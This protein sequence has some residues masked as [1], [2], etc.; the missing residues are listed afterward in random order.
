MN[1]IEIIPGSE[2]KNSVP[3]GKFLTIGFTSVIALLFIVGVIGW[4]ILS[5]VSRS[6]DRFSATGDLVATMDDARLFELTFTRDE[7]PTA[8]REAQES[9]QLT[10]DTAS[11]L[12]EIV[13]DPDRKERL[14]DVVLAAKVYQSEFD[15]FIDLRSKS[16]DA[17]ESMVVAAVQASQAASGLQRIQEK[18][19]RL[20]TESVRQ[21]RQQMEDI[22]ENAADSYEIVVY[23]EKSRE[24]EKN[25]LL[26]G[27]YRELELARSE[28]SNLTNT[29]NELKLR[30]RNPRSI[31]LLDDINTSKDAYLLALSALESNDFDIST[32]TL[33]SAEL[34][35]LDHAAFSMRDAAFSLRSNER[36]V[37]FEIQRIVADTQELMA[38]RLALSEEVDQIIIGVGD[39]R[40]TDRDFSLASTEAE[41]NIHAV[42]VNSLLADVISRS[43]KIQ[44]LLIE[45]DE[46]EIFENVLPS[47][48]QYREDFDSAV[49][50]SLQA[51]E[52]GRL[53]VEFALEADRLLNLAQS[54]RL[55]DISSAR[56][57]AQILAPIGIAFAA[58]LLLLVFLMRRSQQTL[59]EMANKLS[60]ANEAAEAGVKSKS[61]FLAAMSHEIRTPMNGVIGMVDLLSQTRL[62]NDQRQMLSTVQDSGHSLLTIINDIL[63][64]SKI[65]A[66]KLDIEDIDLA[67]V[68]IVEGA[69]QTIAPNAVIKGVKLLTY[70]DPEI[71]KF[72]K[73]DPTRVRQIIINMGGNAIKFSEPGK[74]VLIQAKKV[75]E[76]DEGIA[77]I[78]FSVIDQGVGISEE[79][80]KTLFTEFSQADASTTRKFGGTGL[81]LAICKRLTELMG[82][83]IGVSS[84]HGEG[85]TFW[86][87]LPFASADWTR[88][89]GKVEDLTSMRILVVSL[90]ESYRE[91]C[92]RY[93]Q[94]WNADVTVTADLN[95]CLRLSQ[96]A[97]N[98]GEPIDIIIIPDSD[99]HAKVAETYRAFLDTGMPYPR[100]VIGKDPRAE[101]NLLEGIEEVTMVDI[102]PMRRAG[103]L[104]A[105]AIAAG[106]AS[107]EVFYQKE[108]NLIQAGRTPTVEEALEQ[109]KLILFAED[110]ATNQ[111]VIR[112]QLNALG[113]QCEIA[114]DGKE[115]FE[116]WQAKPYCLLLTD[117]HMP[118]WDGFELTGAIRKSETSS[119]KRA[120]IIAITA[121]AL[122]GESERC[123]AAGM[124]DYMSKPV[125]MSALKQTL[126]KW[127]GEGSVDSDGDDG[128]SADKLTDAQSPAPNP[129]ANSCPVDDSTLKD[130]FGDDDETI[131]EILQGFLEP[132]E[133]IV[134]ELTTALKSRN[135][136]DIHNAAHKL[137]SSARSTGAN[138]LA[139]TSLA[140][141][142]AGREK[143][144]DVIEDLVPT[145]EPL[146]MAVKKYIDD[147]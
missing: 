28:V 4:G 26:S 84:V 92:R 46:K 19:T 144:W 132:T 78:R 113:Y 44:S 135:A 59:F 54:S 89:E 8:A 93:L 145:V 27:N 36:S 76:S 64:F 100:F 15:K 51:A 123:I 101:N 96:A 90:S 130:M 105:A 70:V 147:L 20:D 88:E 24:F 94:H 49:D 72:K 115:A 104:T 83:E 126:V 65:E 82:G 114:N 31:Q 133:K 103:I 129:E 66:G 125:E 23:A 128:T 106:R 34:I 119:D 97:R 127:M 45:D 140:L 61:A 16:A 139:D 138:A 120:P 9:I 95:D 21:F 18:Y 122:Q 7:E 14:E 17:I 91:I 30:I 32:I 131:K 80:Q 74:E 117:C 56:T 124:D 71:A 13:E 110:N 141:E 58:G 39:A 50:V 68:D 38:R 35:D 6:F 75:G 137:K 108:V 42:R 63:D 2:S 5:G 136:D 33:E 25:F 55:D 41:R 47:I 11:S 53:M 86:C 67:V 77:R 73:G 112:K 143:N 109:G 116:M 87:E 142:T 57:S 98:S 29:V 146:F 60:I 48:E 102:N 37:L 99:N 40:Q 79:A 107:P 52:T 111:L 3:N 69:A 22:S 43:I 10:I 62:D 81:G 1:T 85:S 12:Q 134:Q 118:E 121:N